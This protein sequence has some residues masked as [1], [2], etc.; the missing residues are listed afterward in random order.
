[1][2]ENRLPPVRTLPDSI[3]KGYRT[4]NSP[5]SKWPLTEKALCQTYY[6]GSFC[7]ADQEYCLAGLLQY[8]QA[9][10]AEHEGPGDDQAHLDAA[11]AHE[12]RY[13]ALRG[14]TWRRPAAALTTCW[15]NLVLERPER[16]LDRR[17]RATR[18]KT[19]GR[20]QRVENA[21]EEDLSVSPNSNSHGNIFA[22]MAEKIR[23]K[24]L[25]EAK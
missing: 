17:E 18:L 16:I 20:K 13:H 3:G 4:V 5:W 22:E 2:P 6:L 9:F 14:R 7:H 19:T 15:L 8:S 12:V 24:R 11:A 23:L 10:A 21:I 25:R 1:M